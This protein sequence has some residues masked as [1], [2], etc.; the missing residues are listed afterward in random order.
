MIPITTPRPPPFLPS[1]TFENQALISIS[2]SKNPVSF[3]HL[4]SISSRCESKSNP[5]TDGLQKKKPKQ[6]IHSQTTI[7]LRSPHIN[8]PNTTK[9]SGCITNRYI[10][11]LSL[12]TSF[13]THT[14]THTHTYFN[15]ST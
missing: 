13:Y 3:V 2:E 7:Y 1:T 11:Y 12:N 8:L 5:Q 4:E 9:M 14:H 6:R 10:Q 15:I